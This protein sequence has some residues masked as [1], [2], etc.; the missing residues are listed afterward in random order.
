M[1]ALFIFPLLATQ[2]RAEGYVKEI[3]EKTG[4]WTIYGWNIMSP[5]I[6]SATEACVVVGKSYQI[7]PWWHGVFVG[8]K[9]NESYF[10][11]MEMLDCLFQDS[12]TGV[13][14][15]NQGV[16]PL[17]RNVCPAN[18]T[19]G[20]VHC[21][22]N[23]NFK[24]D[25]TATSCVPV[26]TCPAH[27]SRPSADSPCVCDAGY[28]FDAAGTSCVQEQ[29]T[30]ALHNLNV[31]GELSPSAS[32]QAYA[33]VMNGTI[34]Q[35]GTVVT[36][37]SSAPFEAGSLTLSPPSGVTDGLSGRL[38]FIVTAP[39][40]S[41]TY[42]HTLTATC[43]NCSNAAKGA[44]VVSACPIQDL[45]PIT[46]AEVQDF[47]DNP[48]RSDET[49][50]TPRMK[51][52]L[53]CLKTAAAAGS[54]S[55]GSAFRPPAYNQHLIEVWKKWDELENGKHSTNPACSDLKMKIKEHFKTHK[56]KE[57]QPPVPRSLHTQG[58]AVDVTINLSPAKIDALW[59]GCRLYRPPP[60]RIK[61]SV[62]FIHK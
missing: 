19:R 46:D 6:P 13:I 60:L 16:Y 17:T 30:I 41:R 48:D 20:M 38:N 33:Q 14:S 27:A 4:Y 32:R 62:H 31:G 25:P 55:V 37:T 47:E 22:C 7:Y 29:Y 59:P 36:L 50:L 9:P 58:E 42:T 10:A 2:A 39:P 54:P 15:T 45:P 8:T 40:S 57:T 35:G 11:S 49:R 1:A 21:A 3:V 43:T 52:E 12:V 51:T 24:P 28:K 5:G 44:I 34:P 23:T 26:N 61:D 53:A 18:A 56:L